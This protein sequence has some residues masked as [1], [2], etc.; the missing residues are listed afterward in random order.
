MTSAAVEDM[1]ASALAVRAILE[2][3]GLLPD[4]M[5]QFDRN[6]LARRI[7]NIALNDRGRCG[8]CEEAGL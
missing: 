1:T 6:L 7:A 8:Y 4:Q 2:E 3:A 5:S